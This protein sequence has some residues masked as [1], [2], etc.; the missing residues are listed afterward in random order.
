MGDLLIE[1]PFRQDNGN[2][3]NFGRK[4]IPISYVPSERLIWGWPA[5][6]MLDPD[7]PSEIKKRCYEMQAKDKVKKVG[8]PEAKRACCPLLKK[9]MPDIENYTQKLIEAEDDSSKI[10]WAW[11]II[12]AARQITEIKAAQKRKSFLCPK[13]KVYLEPRRRLAELVIQ[14]C[15]CY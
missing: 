2:K 11:G 9:L 4:G 13:C 7:G 8:R 10:K 1:A 14:G 15:R 12:T 6:Y 5:I 3:I